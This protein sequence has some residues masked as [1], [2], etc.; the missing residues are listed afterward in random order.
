MRFE[1]LVEGLGIWKGSRGAAEDLGDHVRRLGPVR[2]ILKDPHL[3]PHES[4]IKIL[5]PSVG[6]NQW[7]SVPNLFKPLVKFS[8]FFIGVV[9]GRRRSGRLRSLVEGAKSA[10]IRVLLLWVGSGEGATAPLLGVGVKVL[11][12]GL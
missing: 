6:R 1:S 3:N 2:E 5:S 12:L 11:V 8:A 9:K 4:A 10:A 7:E